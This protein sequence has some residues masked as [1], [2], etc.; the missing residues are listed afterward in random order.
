MAIQVRRGNEADFDASK[1]L[2][3][4]W[5]VS[6]DTKYVRIC[7]APGLVLR[8]ATYESFE[9]D[10]AQIQAILAECK[11]IQTAI[12]RIQVEVNSNAVLTVESANSAKE[13]ADRAHGEAERALSEAD[14]A[15]S[16]AE[17]A[18]SYMDG[19]ESVIGV[20]L[21]DLY[22][23]KAG[24]IIEKASGESPL[25]IRDTADNLVRNL[26]LYGNTEQ[27]GTSGAQLLPYPYSQT[28]I[29]TNGITFTDNGDGSITVKGTA[30]ADAYFNLFANNET[31]LPLNVGTYI[32]SVEGIKNAGYGYGLRN[33]DG[34]S[35][36][37]PKSEPFTVVD[38]QKLYTHL[39][40]GSGK[41]VD[42]TVYPM[43][44]AGSTALPWEPYTGGQPSPNPDYP[45]EIRSVKGKNLLKNTA[46]SQ[47]INGVTFTVNEDGTVVANGTASANAFL[48]VGRY[49]LQ[50]ENY[51]LNGCPSG[52]SADK[53]RIMVNTLN[54]ATVWEVDYGSGVTFSSTKGTEV[55][56]RLLVS[57]GTT[58]S[59]LVFKPM[60]R[61]ASIADPTYVPYG[62]LRVKAHGKNL[63]P[64]NFARCDYQN[65]DGV[66]VAIATETH[67][68][69][70][71][72]FPIPMGKTLTL[73][74]NHAFVGESNVVK[75]MQFDKNGVFMVRH[76]ASRASNTITFIPDDGCK[77]LAIVI[78]DSNAG[79]SLDSL[80]VQLEEGTE[81]TA[82]EPYT[83]NSITL[84]QPIVLN[85]PNGVRDRFVEKDG[86]YGVERKFAEVVFDGDESWAYDSSVKRVY[87][88]DIQS[89]AKA[90]SANDM[91]AN[92]LSDAFI[93]K[94]YSV[95]QTDMQGCVL[96]TSATLSL[97]SDGFTSKDEWLA[98]MAENPITVIYEVA[99]PTFE[100][101]PTADQI[102]LRSLLSYDGVT[103]LECDSEVVPTIEAECVLDTKRYIDRKFA[104][105]ATALV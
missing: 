92:I 34:T 69:T 2:P 38:G 27:N 105:L 95:A 6:L 31:A 14:R 61:R 55:Q 5:A 74:H 93:A 23:T 89:V 79:V 39:V 80:E 64:N 96:S 32:L 52:G 16:E 67:A 70:P 76:S 58:V 83:E 99:E 103:Y 40:V 20:K 37:L 11:Y 48:E 51:I 98:Y 15:H 102:A 78:Y 101:L 4:E 49:V 18:K 3:G 91:K 75:I 65:E 13:S 25:C 73:S 77:Y 36:S 54:D 1:M 43:L 85:G 12:E 86:V 81:A 35:K 29:T 63:C 60:I 44:N 46:T 82:Y 90:P 94:S 26:K 56:C 53:Y 57:A 50:E 45:Q 100:P 22:Q 42:E 28:T 41:K 71:D 66:K 72:K 62:C 7:L 19:A 8:M 21:A 9:A 24:A 97:F 30:T 10:R 87:T 17:R 33:A 84:S 88:T 68:G 104:E 47:T 59:N